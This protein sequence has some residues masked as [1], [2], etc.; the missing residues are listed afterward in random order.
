MPL[1]KKKEH[2]M[3]NCSACANEHFELQSKFLGLPCFE[4]ESIV[5]LNIPDASKYT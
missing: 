3:T 2:T 5:T 1:S 4:P